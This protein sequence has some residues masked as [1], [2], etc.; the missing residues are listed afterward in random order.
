MKYIFFILFY[1]FEAHKLKSKIEKFKEDLIE[2]D[3]I[4]GLANLIPPAPKIT[5]RGW[6]RLSSPFFH[7]FYNI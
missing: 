5:A 7:V 1:Y 3:E 6:L 2:V 4:T